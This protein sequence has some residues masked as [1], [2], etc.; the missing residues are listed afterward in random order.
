MNFIL[1]L[2]VQFAIFLINLGM[3]IFVLFRNPKSRIHQ[4]FC[5]FAAGLAGWNL[6]LFLTISEIGQ[7]LLWGRLAFAFGT[8]MAPG[9]FIFATLFPRITTPR[10]GIETKIVLA[11]GA[12]FTLL[13]LTP[14]LVKSVTVMDRLYITGELSPLYFPY[15]IY[16]L[17]MLIL[18]FFRLLFK[19][20]VSTGVHKAQ[21]KVITAGMVVFFVPFLS[22]QLILPLF[23]IFWLNNLGPLFS[24]FMVLAIGYAITHYRFLDIRSLIQGGFLYLIS[25]GMVSVVYFLSV[26]FV[27]RLLETRILHT[28]TQTAQ[29]LGVVVI[30][31]VIIIGY[32]SLKNLLQKATDRIF[33]RK[34]Y[35]REKLLFDLTHTIIEIIDMDK[36]IERVL[37]KLVQEMRLSKAAFLIVDDHKIS[38]LKGVGFRDHEL[39]EPLFEQLFHIP[40]DGIP[41]FVFDELPE[42]HSHKELFRKFDISIA[43]PL[44]V[45]NNEVA[46]LILGPKLSGDTYYKRDIE[47]LNLF[48]PQA[49]IAIF[50]AKAY[51]EIKRFSQELETRVS[52]RT[53]ELEESQRKELAKAEEVMKLKDE[54]VFIAAHELRSPVVA[55]RGFLELTAGAKK[56]FPKDIQHNLDAIERASNHLNQ[57]I[58]DLLNVARTESGTLTVRMEPH[59]F[60]S[61]L[62]TVAEEFRPRLEERR[63]ALSFDLHPAPLVW[64]DTDKLRE[65]LRNLL[66]NAIKYNKQGGA[67]DVSVYRSPDERTLICEVRDTGYGI[68]KNQQHKM[69]QKF[70]RADC[71]VTREML[72]TGL[73]LFITKAIIEKMGGNISF[74]S[75]EGE[76]TTFTFTL[77]LAY[78]ENPYS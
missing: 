60:E 55:I 30:S 74:S 20:R 75:V 40:N 38:M 33:F 63:V 15:L 14:F 58:N 78:K 54:F 44:R 69:F 6:S 24:V 43:I 18:A 4:Y 31:T 12:F 68:P 36:F 9:L 34:D 11:L 53:R 2:S 17:G 65:V 35:V 19:H 10:V 64:C 77:P 37:R 29:A 72:G 56:Q 39:A 16:Y 62:L 71:S 7:P 45:E 76:G 1:I 32:S 22:T 52:E 8:L 21:L 3:G 61:I 13:S 5:L 23:G 25:L 66:D 28:S 48:A 47:I 41:F 42:D 57:L 49:A 73:G 67:I 59:N 70:F 27:G 50:N 46:I 26:Y 51:T